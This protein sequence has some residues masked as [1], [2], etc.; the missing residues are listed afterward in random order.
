VTT[1][2]Y[3]L[4]EFFYFIFKPNSSLESLIECSVIFRTEIYNSKLY[5]KARGSQCVVP[6]DISVVTLT[7]LLLV[8]HRRCPARSQDRYNVE[9]T[10][11]KS[12]LSF[13]TLITIYGQAGSLGWHA[14][15]T[16]SI[17]FLRLGII[18]KMCLSFHTYSTCSLTLNTAL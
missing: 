5:V 15:I 1:I 14:I 2:V 11:D 13:R 6:K 3:S 7:H 9:F 4:R 17:I 10:W 18:K 8:H 12:H 16:D